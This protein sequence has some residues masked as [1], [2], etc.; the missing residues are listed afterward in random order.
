MTTSAICS[1]CGVDWAGGAFSPGCGEC[2][3]GAMERPCL[4]CAGRCG[5]MARRAVHDSQDQQ[6]G[7]WLMR[8]AL[9]PVPPGRAGKTKLLA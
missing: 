2:D 3:G 4:V 9:G 8:C 5:V 7:V 1:L 6:M